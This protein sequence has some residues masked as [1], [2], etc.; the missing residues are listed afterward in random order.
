MPLFDDLQALLAVQA[1]DTRIGRARQTLAV[2]DTGAQTAEAY[3]SAK[4]HADGLRAQ[5]VKAQTEQRDAEL[6]LESI[7][8]K[9]AQAQKN[10]FGGKV[11]GPRELENLQREIEMLGRQKNDAEETTLVAMETAAAQ[12]ASAAEAE[13][14]ATALADTYRKTRAVYKKRH[15]EL[16]AEI[17]QAEKERAQ[18]IKPVPPALLAR[19][20]AIRPKKNNVGVAVLQADETCG[21][22]H[23]R[24]NTGLLDEVKASAG[25]PLCEYCGRILVP[26]VPKQ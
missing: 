11:A 8:A 15:A 6:R 1:V 24:L 17:A 10:L 7:E 20:D 23:T 2:I 25:T 16:S 14:A 5:A 19:Y 22:C 26:E 4:A 18:A 3:A 9:A 12:A 21:A 13:A